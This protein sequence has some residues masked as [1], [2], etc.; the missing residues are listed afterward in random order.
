MLRFHQIYSRLI[1]FAVLLVFTGAFCKAD[2]ITDVLSSDA[3]APLAVCL[4][5][6]RGG[7]CGVCVMEKQDN[8]IK[9][10]LFNEFGI[11]AFN[12]VY[13]VGNGKIKLVDVIPF[14]NRW[15]IK[16]II[17]GDLKYLFDNIP[18]VR[19]SESKGRRLEIADDSVTLTNRKYNIVYTFSNTSTDET[20]E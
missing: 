11:T 20:I 4:D 14:L 2:C 19:T 18:V 7:F 13:S 1:S 9:G 6:D 12:F 17:K 3:G 8:D 16:K 15:Y 10:S 5:T